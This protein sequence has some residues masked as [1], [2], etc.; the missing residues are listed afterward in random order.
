MT[1][2][3]DR[4]VLFFDPYSYSDELI[5]NIR[6]N[7]VHNSHI[8]SFDNFYNFVNSLMKEREIQ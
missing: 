4:N 6:K 1:I 5:T 8:Y 3:L 2:G 7:I